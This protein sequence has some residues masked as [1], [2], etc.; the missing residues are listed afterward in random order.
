M[1]QI[2][3]PRAGGPE[4][5]QIREKEDPEPKRGEVAIRVKAAGINFA[6]ILARKGLYPD[7]PPMPCVVGYEVSGIVERTG[8]GVDPSLSGTPVLAI[9]RFGGYADFV[10]VP[11]RQVFP[12]PEA[13]SFEAAAALPVNYLTAYQAIVV[14]GGLRKGET[15]LIHNAGGGV[16]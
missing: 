16:G 5:F 15:I 14:M 4:V 7:A 8:E 10:V 6:D 13:L 12:K 3:I 9:T 11:E 1:R 2:V